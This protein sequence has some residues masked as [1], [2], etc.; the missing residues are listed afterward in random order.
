MRAAVHKEAKHVVM[1]ENGVALVL[2]V[3]ADMRISEAT[4]EAEAMIGSRASRA[5]FVEN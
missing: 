2:T 1:R 3:F 5:A 4:G